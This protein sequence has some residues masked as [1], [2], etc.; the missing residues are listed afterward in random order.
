MKRA[1]T[2]TEILIAMSI[3]ITVLVP[4][5]S[6]FGT[7][8]RAI[9]KSTIFSFATGLAR[10]I[11]QHLMVIPFEDIQEVSL[12]GIAVADGTDDP[13]FNPLINFE[14][15]SAGEKKISAENFPELHGFLTL[16][17]FRYSLSVSNVS[18]GKGDE[19]KDVGI[20]ITWQENGKDM[21]YRTHVFVPSI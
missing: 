1:I 19:I 10:R 16:H 20:L 2:L 12:P 11:S 14:T 3:A 5:V 8:G 4:V 18:F 21:M 9:Q 17:D 7:A 13:F 6:M 15:T